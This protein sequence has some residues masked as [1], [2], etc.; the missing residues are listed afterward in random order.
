[1][2]AEALSWPQEALLEAE[3]RLIS[4]IRLSSSFTLFLQGERAD[5][6]WEPKGAL[7]G[8]TSGME[9]RIG[10]LI[11]GGGIRMYW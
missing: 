6:L 3:V 11:G 7:S 10:E 1:M 4:N 5:L 2:R 9:R 8:F